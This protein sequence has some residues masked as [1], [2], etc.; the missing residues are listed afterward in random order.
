MSESVRIQSVQSPVIPDVAALI[1]G[2]ISI[3]IGVSCCA[4]APRDAG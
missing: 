2:V 3:A 1:K 4:A